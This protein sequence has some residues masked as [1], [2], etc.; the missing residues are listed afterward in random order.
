MTMIISIIIGIVIGII[1]GALG[2][3]AMILDR[4]MDG[5]AYVEVRKNGETHRFGKK[6][7]D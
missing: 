5:S 4:T 2:A 3:G 7:D 1:I 6:L